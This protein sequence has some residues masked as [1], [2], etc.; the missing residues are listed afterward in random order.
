MEN[1]KLFELMTKMYG[2]MQEG[3][4]EMKDEVK[5]VKKQLNEFREETNTRFDG[6]EDKINNLEGV[7]AS[8]HVTI[9]TKLEKV[10]DDLD[11]LSHKE[12]Q[13]ERDMYHLKQ[14]LAKSKR[15][16]K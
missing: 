5:D 3:F 9:K 11:F 16:A 13:A 2:E 4:K 10:S 8:N 15:N 14:R 12:F 6:L 7:N 1:D